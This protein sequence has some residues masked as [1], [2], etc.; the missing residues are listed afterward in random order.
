MSQSFLSGI[1]YFLKRIMYLLTLC[2]LHFQMSSKIKCKTSFQDDWLTNNLVSG[3][4]KLKEMYIVLN[5]EFDEKLYLI[6]RN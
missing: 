4:K 6:P 1:I 2:D 5:V 3:Y